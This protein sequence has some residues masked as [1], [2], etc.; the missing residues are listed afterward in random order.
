MSHRQVKLNMSKSECI[1][2]LPHLE[3]ILLLCFRFQRM[4]LLSSCSIQ[5]R[6][7]YSLPLFHPPQSTQHEVLS[8]LFPQALPSQISQVLA[9]VFAPS[10]PS[11]LAPLDMC[12]VSDS[13]SSKRDKN[14]F[15]LLKAE[16]EVGP[17]NMVFI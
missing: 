12:C 5:I 14:I 11:C 9:H 10:D 2:F 3:L 17:G 4:T 15:S 16:L 6:Y 13:K 8:M 1:I 7:P